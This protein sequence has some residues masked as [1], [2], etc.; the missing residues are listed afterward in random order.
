MRYLARRGR[1]G[2]TAALFQQRYNEFSANNA[3]LIAPFAEE[4]KLVTIGTTIT[5]MPDPEQMYEGFKAVL[6]GHHI[7]AQLFVPDTVAR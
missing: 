4:G 6:K 7:G 5:N 3:E 2:D 1:P